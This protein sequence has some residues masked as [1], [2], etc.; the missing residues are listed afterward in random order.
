VTDDDGSAALA[1]EIQRPSAAGIIKAILQRPQKE[2]ATP[3]VDGFKR[4][5]Y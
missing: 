4:I 1:G 5:I 2:F 3:I